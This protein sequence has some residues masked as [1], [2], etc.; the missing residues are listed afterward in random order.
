MVLNARKLFQR[1]T[2]QDVTDVRA[3]SSRHRKVTADR[4]NQ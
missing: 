3:K 4:W 2:P 1:G